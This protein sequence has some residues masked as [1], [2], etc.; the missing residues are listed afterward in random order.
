MNNIAIHNSWFTSGT[1]QINVLIWNIFLD[2][3]NGDIRW[4]Y[5]IRIHI[6]YTQKIESPN[7]PLLEISSGTSIHKNFT[8]QKPTTKRY[9]KK[10]HKKYQIH[11]ELPDIDSNSIKKNIY[12]YFHLKRHIPVFRPGPGVRGLFWRNTCVEPRDDVKSSYGEREALV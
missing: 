9:K 7:N 2:W 3:I 8:Y 12:I 10:T 1:S 6:I 11:H 5:N 4:K